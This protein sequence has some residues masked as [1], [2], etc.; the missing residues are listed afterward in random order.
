MFIVY[1]LAI[2]YLIL[3]KRT[4]LLYPFAISSLISFIWVF[5]ARNYYYYN[6]NFVVL[7]K[8]NLFPLFAWALGL[9]SF[10]LAYLHYEPFLIKKIGRGFIKM[11][12]LFSALYLP[13]L[14]L[15]EDI[16]YNFLDIHNL[17][18]ANYSGLP[19]CNCLHGPVWLKLAYFLMG[20]VFFTICYFLRLENPHIEIYNR[21]KKLIRTIKNA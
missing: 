16:G 6:Y 9:F 15:V 19:F 4:S 1:L 11:L 7:W 13:L 17:A 8:I 14:I 12:A 10:Y 21:T 3:S 20:P 18:A 5:L 2:P